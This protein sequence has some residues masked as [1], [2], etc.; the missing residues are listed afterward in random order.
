M[1]LKPSRKY[2]KGL[3]LLVEE[4]NAIDSV[5]IVTSVSTASTKVPVSALPNVDNLSDVVVYS[6]F[7]SQSN[8][9]QLDND[10][11]KQIDV[12]DLEEIDLKWQMAMLTMR[13][14]SVMVLVAM[15]RAFRQMK[16]QQTMPSW[17]SPPQVL[18][19]LIM[20]SESDVSMPTIPVHDRVLV[21]KPHKKTPYE[22]LLDAAAF[23]VKE[24]DFEVHVSP[25]SSDKTKKHNEK[26]KREAKGKSPVELS[27]GVRDLSDEFEEFSDNSTNEVNATSTPVT[28]VGPNL[29]NSTNTFHV[30]GPFN[31]AVS[32]EE[33]VGV[34]AD[35]VNLET[36]ITISPIPT[37]KVHK[38]HHITQIIGDLFLAPQ[39]RSMAR[40]V[41]EQGGLTQINDEDFHTCSVH[42]DAIIFGSTN[43]ELCKAF[44]KLMKDKF[45]MSSIGELTFFLG[46]QVKQKQDGIFIR[47]DKYVAEIL[48]K[49]GIIDGKSASTPIDIEKPLLKDPDGKDVDVHTYRSMISSLMYLTSSRPN[50][51]FV[52]CVCAH[53]QDTP[54]ASHLHAVKRIFRYLKGKP[55]LG[56]W[57]P[58]DSPFNLVAYSD[59]DYAG[60]SLD[61]KSTTG[62]CQFLGCRLI[63]CN[64]ALAIPG[65]TE[66]GEENSNPLMAD[67]DEDDTLEEVDAEVIMDANVQ[68]RLEE[69]Q[70]NVYHLDLE[71][72]EKVLTM[73]D[74][75]ETE[76]VKVK[77][78]IEVVTA[79]KLI[80]KVV[81]IAATT[82]TAAPVPKA[83]ALRRRRGLIIQDPEGAATASVI[84]QSEDEAFARELEAELNANINWNDVVDQVKRKER[85]DNTAIRYQALKRKLVTKAQ[86]RKNMMIVAND[87]DDDVYTEATPLALKTSR[88]YAKGLLLLVKELNAIDSEIKSKDKGKGILAEEP[89]PLKREAQIE[90]DEA[91]ARELEAELNANINWK[92][93]IEQVKRN[94]RQDNTVMR[95]KALKKKHSLSDEDFS[96]KIFSNPLFEE[97]IIPIKIDLHH[98][99][100]KSDLIESM[101][102]RDSSII[103]SSSKIDSLLD[104]F[105]EFV[106]DNSN[107]EI[108][109]FSPSPIP[110]KDSDSFM[111]EIN[112]TFTPDDPMPPGIKEDDYDSK[113]DILILEELLYDPGEDIHLVE[114]LLYDNSSP[115]PP[116]EF[117]SENSNADIES[118]S[119]SPIPIKD[120]DSF[121]EEINLSFNPDD[122]MP[123]SIEEDDNDFERD[124]LIHEELLDNYSLSLT[125]NESFRF[126]IP[127][128]SRPP[129]KPPDGN[130]RI[131]NIKR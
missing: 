67:A 1:L 72:A 126:D 15:T 41:K 104:E 53:F 86:A 30:V 73:Q 54:K 8:S 129:A 103:S 33:D 119:P 40:M 120:S 17:H 57:Y 36:N 118:F 59:S 62:C 74:T 125:V 45:Y 130:T 114:R 2:A 91:F 111:E 50:I 123:P 19:V 65:Q 87:D 18:P 102:N 21:T 3:L 75:D 81:T 43:K 96:E 66:T 93:V 56:L 11:L 22:L 69:S 42:M 7:S 94:E 31:T 122:P 131:L 58:K 85:Q 55:H 89:K 121:M 101:L 99:N 52:V 63:S 44:E 117:V 24:P 106:S 64:E 39:T 109:S 80:T 47:Q 14:R 34:K 124:I 79:A 107:A 10:D 35:F 9:P 88:K 12:D 82:I 98:H 95:Y 128:F 110:V 16:N 6:F 83:S 29:T 68:G 60:A 127:S 51:M 23:E 77:E 108:E 97:E 28:A 78:V 38:D 115:R 48:R 13:A 32:D 4:L 70:A 61:R 49:F 5:S 46:L 113:R 105:V 92:E 76:P 90:Q 26:T 71:H 20:S 112:L 116:E 27:I 100:A 84:M 37:T 25:S